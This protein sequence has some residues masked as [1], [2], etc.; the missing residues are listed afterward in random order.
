[1]S[2]VRIVVALWGGLY[3]ALGLVQVP[4]DGDLWWQRWL[5]NVVLHTHHLPTSLGSETF[6]A[7]GAPWVPQE[8]VF[9]VLVALAMSHGAFFIVRFLVSAIPAAILVLIYL[10]SR[11][12]AMPEAIGVVLLFCGMAF[13]ESF[14][15]R[16]QV[17]G[18]GCL[19]AFLLTLE[20][21]DRWFYATIPIVVIWANLH[22]SVMIAPAIV[23]A[24]ILGSALDG[25][26]AALRAS[27]DLRI[28][29]A[30]LAG[31]LCTPFGWHLPAFAVA[32]ANSPIREYIVEWRPV[33]FDDLSFTFAGLPVMLLVLLNPRNFVQ[34]KTES[35]PLAMLFV[36]MILAGR[37]IPLFV[38]TA[39]PLAARNLGLAFPQLANLGQKLREM[40][41]VA[42][43]M[44]ALALC[45]SP[46]ALSLD[47]LHEPPR[48]PNALISQ[49]AA[50]HVDYRLFCENFTWC[51]IALQFPNLR[52]YMDGR[53]DAY[54]LDVWKSYVSAAEVK[55]SW[56]RALRK[57]DVDAV[58]ASRYGLLAKSLAATAR[59][60]VSFQDSRYV[61]FLRT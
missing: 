12:Q 52:V 21:R 4:G 13:K 22:A 49:L 5:G 53:C 30:L 26:I 32:F 29:P 15:I 46:V 40:E 8:W 50:N 38:I 44:I 28:L 39:A 56:K 35:L 54:P 58:V 9:S 47:Q 24:R 34:R 55:P 51:S 1:M 48:L 11:D 59:W 3:L 18:W 23:I 31:V 14:G 27:R 16:A 37:N 57:Y 17:L 36:A 25:G 60:R 45:I 42:L 43:G 19:A 61:V 20:R 6:T 7:A 41:P 33:R 2:A 10:R